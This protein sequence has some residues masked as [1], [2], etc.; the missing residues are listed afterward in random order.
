MKSAESILARYWHYDSFRHP[1]KDIITTIVSGRDTL[2]L[3]PTGGGKSLCY[4]IPALMLDGVCLVISPLVA[5][6]KDQVENLQKKG[7]KAACI[8]A[9]M[10]TEQQSNV[11]T[12]CLYGGLKLLYVSPE[13]LNSWLF[14]DA[15]KRI[16]VSLIAVD[17]AH[18]ISQWGYDFRPSYLEIAKIRDYFPQAPLIALTATATPQVADDICT[19][20]SL[21]NVK[22]FIS[23]FY[24]SNLSYMVFHEPDKYG[25]LLRIISKVGGTGIVYVPS[26]RS[27][28]I[29]SDY[30]NAHNIKSAYYHAG[31]TK[32]M[33]DAVQNN[34]MEEK[35]QVI[36]ATTAF[37][38]G[39]DKPNVRYV[40]HTFI[41]SSIES[42]F[43][44]AGRGGRDGKKAYSVMLYIESDIEALE[45]N[46]EISYP[47][48]EV[49]KQVYESLC[50]YY[51][52]PMGGGC[53]EEFLFEPDN[54]CQ[55]YKLRP[56]LLRSSIG[57]LEK[58]GF[59]HMP[60]GED[61]S[62]RLIIT[63]SRDDLYMFMDSHP[64][65]A[66]L[67]ERMMRIYGGL[68]LE[69]VAVDEQLIAKQ[70]GLDETSVTDMLQHLNELGVVNYK[71]GTSHPTIVF[72]TPRCDLRHATLGGSDYRT[73]KECAIARKNAMLEYI[74]STTTCR[75]NLLLSYFGETNV[76]ECGCC[77]V[78]IGKKKV[79][80][81]NIKNAIVELLGQRKM[82]VK[83]LMF[84]FKDIDERVLLSCVRSLV[85]DRLIGIDRDMNLYK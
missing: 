21:I 48:V 54:I 49:I 71:I 40:I 59:I 18:C 81:E 61:S 83:Q 74:R 64:R 41:P 68:F 33:R 2:V 38:M 15:I 7:I 34:W 85:D 10:T 66:E 9:G 31:L 26:Q 14:I 63:M 29:Y 80:T 24:R 13:R 50:S 78:C 19:K 3:M 70:I 35:V 67:L 57:F 84:E 77:D 56:S 53:N 58:E 46:I 42:Y 47:K 39:I 6:M 20:L 45:Q 11:F 75:S 12:N 17:E 5:L 73:L 51:A 44:E 16:K 60:N 82:S 69:S 27:A 28:K 62:S 72:T 52:I 25:R 30:L 65:Y 32:N 76:D 22:R 37:G 43:Q 36:V 4:Q 55:K 23:S 8:V 79:E 1:Q